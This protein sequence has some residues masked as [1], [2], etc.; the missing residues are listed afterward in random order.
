[1]M[2]IELDSA[3][4]AR[5]IT[6]TLIPWRQEHRVIADLRGKAASSRSFSS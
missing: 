5:T 3:L 2:R 4:H 6:S 1:M